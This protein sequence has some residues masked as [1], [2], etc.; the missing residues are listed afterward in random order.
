MRGSRAEGFAFLFPDGT[1]LGEIPA[2]DQALAFKNAFD[3]L[4]EARIPEQDVHDALEH[5][6]EQGITG[7]EEEILTAAS[8]WLTYRPAERDGASVVSE[9]LAAYG[10]PQGTWEVTWQ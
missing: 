1:P 6:R 3:A 4:L 7:T 8:R 2:H 10:V 9:S 5:V